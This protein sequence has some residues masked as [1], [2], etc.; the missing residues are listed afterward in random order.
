MTLRE[1]MEDVRQRH[2]ALTPALVVQEARANR[3]NAG[4]LLNAR[5]EW[6][7]DVAAEAHRIDQ[8]RE[9]IRTCTVVY[10]EATETEGPQSMRAFHSVSGPD[11]HHYE[12][13]EVVAQD[14]LMRAM[15]LRDMER[16]WKALHRRY[17]AFDEFARM[18]TDSLSVA[19]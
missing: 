19:A 17:A 16:D 14:P 18:V 4:K 11:G 2:G 12:P 8:A 6:R 3:T 7:D 10:R 5:L 9:L 1:A 15:V 13:A